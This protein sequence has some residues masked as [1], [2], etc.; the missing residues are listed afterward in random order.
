MAPRRQRLS[1]RRKAAELAQKSLAHGLGVERSTVARWQAADT[2]PLPSIRPDVAVSRSSRVTA[3]AQPVS[4]EFRYPVVVDA[5]P[6]AAIAPSPALPGLLAD[7]DHPA[8]IN[9]IGTDLRPFEP[10]PITVEVGGFAGSRVPE[11][12]PADVADFSSVTT[13]PLNIPFTDV[14]RRPDRP[15]GFK[16]FAAAGVLALIGS[17]AYVSLLTPDNG[18]IPPA[19]AGNPAP[20]A[21]VAAIP[22][23]D[24]GSSNEFTGALPAARNKPANAPAASVSKPHT[25]R[26]TNRSKPAASKITSPRPRTPAIP[27]EAYAWSQMAELSGSDQSRSRLRSELPPG[28]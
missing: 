4:A 14:R 12:G 19:T 6:E 13:V 11:P 15:P 9:I 16:R 26:S 7:I 17:A 1:Q 22:A 21:P 28:P 24:P 20:A 2:Q 18:L 23:P 3:L 27:A 10:A 5:D 8:D 25:A